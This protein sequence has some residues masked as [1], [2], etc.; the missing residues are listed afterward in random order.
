MFNFTGLKK[1]RLLTIML[2]AVL[3]LVFSAAT[4][5]AVTYGQQGF[6]QY[7]T[8][9]T[10][11]TNSPYPVEYVT[12]LNSALTAT[13]EGGE[14]W[15]NRIEN[16]Y[17]ISNGKDVLIQERFTSGANSYSDFKWM[18]NAMRYVMVVEASTGKIVANWRNETP[19]ADGRNSSGSY[20]IG[21]GLVDG[22][23]AN[24]A[25]VLY[26]IPNAAFEYD[27]TYYFINGS[28]TCGNNNA[29][30]IFAP[31]IFQFTTSEADGNGTV[32][33]NPNP[34]ERHIITVNTIKSAEDTVSKVQFNRYNGSGYVPG[35]PIYSSI[36]GQEIALIQ[37]IGEGLSMSVKITDD[38]GQALP[39]NVFT[40]IEPG[41][42]NVSDYKDI[43]FTMTN[44]AVTVDVIFGYKV[45]F[46]FQD[47]SG[48]AQTVT[49]L[50]VAD[51]DRTYYAETDGSFILPAGIYTCFF[52]HNDSLRAIPLIEVTEDGTLT[53]TL[54][55]GGGSVVQ[56]VLF[57][58]LPKTILNEMLVVKNSNGTVMTVTTGR[59]YSLAAGTYTYTVDAYGYL[60]KTGS[61]TV[62]TD[63]MIT[64]ELTAW[65]DM[66]GNGRINIFD[67]QQVLNHI[68]GL[69]TPL[70]GDALTA[71]DMDGNGK[72]NIFDL[73]KILNI[74]YGLV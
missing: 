73:Q 13:N 72:I 50:S 67:L 22:Y 26:T 11:N 74:I 35:I 54:Y 24:Q 71:A 15:L 14:Y 52:I 46:A 39:Q 33:E 21:Y 62:P 53:L 56:T 4:A 9:Y 60:S 10:P 64:V 42:G 48:N 28:A 20:Q 44:S 63:G 37:T 8:L 34:L 25:G 55:N 38:A 2:A 51:G 58:I 70:S 68:Y 3:I 69:G 45:N 7:L 30:M 65:G 47:E 43:R 18:Y 32:E 16:F 41:D 19:A 31:I 61:F 40:I 49:Y 27:T 66:D 23:A 5:L 6:N 29:R 17:D 59:L 36:A 1:H 57:D 12:V